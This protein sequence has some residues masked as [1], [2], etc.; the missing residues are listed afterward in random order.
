[1]AEFVIER[2]EWHAIIADSYRLPEDTDINLMQYTEVLLG[3][4][5]SEDSELREDFAYNI[6]A[7]WIINHRYQD[8]SELRSMISWLSKEMKTQLGETDNDELLF[9]RSHAALILSLIMYRDSRENFLD[10]I[11]VQV[12]LHDAQTYLL[13]ERDTRAYIEGSGWANPI[14]N[15]ADLLRYIVYN[16]QVSPAEMQYLLS[17]IGE[18]LQQSADESF[19]HDEEERL[20]KVVIAIMLQ[21]V[22]TSYD[23]I[24]WL[25]TFYVWR[26]ET[27]LAT[28]YDFVAN[29]T[30]QNIKRFL[31]ALFIHME[32]NHMPLSAQD[33]T[34]E[35]LSIIQEFKL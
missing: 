22:L 3:Y 33:A 19:T 32:I 27:D 28:T 11:E 6:L 10:E 31:F 5:S 29:A 15:V 25:R 8:E 21:D 34:G 23:L 14:A 24:D 18:K 4:L 30:Y 17:T 26:Q 16:P 7:R 20:A 9:L 35:L 13:E 2:D 1:M 12:V